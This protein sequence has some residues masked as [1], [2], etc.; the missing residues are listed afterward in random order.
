MNRTYRVSVKAEIA[1][2]LEW[3]GDE[4]PNALDIQ[5]AATAILENATPAALD[6]EGFSIA[7]LQSLSGCAYLG[8]DE[9]GN[10]QVLS[11]DLI[12]EEA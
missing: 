7:E 11:S 8:W 10:V 4:E 6:A 12:A 3:E 5:A 9:S 2:D 1:F